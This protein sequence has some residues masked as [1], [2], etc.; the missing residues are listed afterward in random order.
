MDHKRN[1]QCR[2]KERG[3]VSHTALF[4]RACQLPE[5]SQRQG[6]DGM[7][8][9][10]IHSTHPFDWAQRI[11]PTFKLFT[12]RIVRAFHLA[13]CVKLK[14]PCPAVLRLV[15]SRKASIARGRPHVNR[16]LRHFENLLTPER[17]WSANPS[18]W[19]RGTLVVGMKLAVWE[20]REDA[21]ERCMALLEIGI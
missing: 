14:V 12:L 2:H 5:Y 15:G 19:L 7:A 20:P 6:Y 9:V 4:R 21:K 8:G 10:L 16:D 13:A 1:T 11:V 18:V 3:W 17:W